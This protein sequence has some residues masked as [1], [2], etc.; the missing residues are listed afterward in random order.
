[1]SGKLVHLIT[2]VLAVGLVQTSLAD[3]LDPNLV[4]WWRFDEGSGTVAA[5]SSGQDLHG[6]LVN[7]PVWREDGPRDG[8]LFFD[9]DDAYVWVAQQDALNPSDGSFTVTFWAHAEVARGTRG[10][11]NW[12]LAVAKRDSGSAGYYIGADRNQGSAEETGYR[13]MLGDIDASR[14]DT[15]FV[16]VPLGEWV[17]VASV[18]DRAQNAQKISVDG[19]QTWET[20]IPPAGPVAPVRDLGIGWDIGSNNFWF[21]GKIDDVAFFNR[22]LSDGQINLIMQEG[23]TPAL[24]KDSYPKDRATD[25]P[26]DAVLS[27]SPGLYASTHDVYFGTSSADVE[28]ATKT[29]P[30]GV[31]VSPG[32]S[33]SEYNPGPLTLGQTYYWRIDEVNAPSQPATFTGEIWSFTVEP[34]AYALEGVTV[35]ASGDS[36]PGSGPENTVNGSGLND[37]DQ[38]SVETT[39]MWLSAPGGAEPLQ[40]VYEFDKIYSLHEMW[41][42]N[43][44]MELEPYVKFGAKDVTVEHS[45]DGVEWTLLDEAEFAQAPGL[46]TY[47]ANTAVPFGGVVA[48]YVRLTI[49]SNWGTSDQYGLS[50]V[51]FLYTPLRARQPDPASETTDLPPELTLSWRPGR[52]AAR[53][54][55]YLST[56]EQAVIEGTAPVVPVSEARFDPGMLDLGQA[57]Y[58]KVDE[59][60]EADAISIWEGDTWTLS[61][62]EYIIVDDFESYTDYSPNRIFQTWTDGWG[63]SEDDFFPDGN[64]GNGTGAQVGN[65]DPPFAEGT[66]IYS[67][68]Q[69]MPLTYNNIAPL[70]YSETERSFNEPQNWTLYGIGTLTVYFRGTLDNGGRLYAKINGTKVPY[71]GDAGDIAKLLWQPWNI[72]LSTVGANLQSVQTLAIGVEDADATGVLYIDDIRLYP[73]PP[74]STIPVEPDGA[75]L[76]AH[77]ALDGDVTD[78]SGNGHHGE[79]VGDPVYVAGV[80][81]QAMEFDG[82]DDHVRI[83]HHDSLNPSDGN[84]SIAFWA[85]L[86]PMPG[87]GGT[88]TWDMA[89]G[90][91]DTGSKGYYVGADRN[92]GTE[93]QAGFKFMLGNT[94]S[95]RVDTPYALVSL[96]EWVLVTA[97]LD[98]EQDVHRISVDAGHTWATATPPSGSVIPAEDLAIG[99]DIGP[100]NY[101]FRGTVDEVRLYNIALSDEEVAWLAGN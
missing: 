62:Q 88:P 41:V 37:D 1:M 70:G 40:L 49:N 59:V 38:H 54:D 43:Y 4:G 17:F 66:V 30:L 53:H 101:W 33:A 31:Q 19:G 6:T 71:N 96:G 87:T 29:D 57:Y 46:D 16:T 12:D 32:Q 25:V 68:R 91:R 36:T 64:D 78:S 69:S 80:R 92:Q 52:H 34:I 44:N 9:G 39:E 56:D 60:N 48:R 85:L 73:R 3:V 79:T 47:T 26:F 20:A 2:L 84:F 83:A 67:G 42:W 75:N 51:R 72:D 89:V 100:N 95:N 55:V 65:I 23:M 76:I 10:D 24:A 99:F 35:T 61:T 18:L 74:E 97:V 27:W 45:V 13:F 22:A 90:K 93:N 63:F 28:A 50:E 77:Y 94:L 86:D 15:P 14:V 58:W 81:G 8:C 5:D 11:T 98:G 7:D 21:H 82:A